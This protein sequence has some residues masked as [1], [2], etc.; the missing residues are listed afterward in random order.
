MSLTV[1]SR[2]QKKS[3]NGHKQTIGQNGQ[4]GQN[5]HRKNGQKIGRN[6]HRIGYNVQT[7]KNG[8]N[9]CTT[10]Y[11]KQDVCKTGHVKQDM[12]NRTC[13]IGQNRQ[14]ELNMTKQSK[15]GGGATPRWI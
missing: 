12:K 14:T 1:L 9:T 7:G 11:L 2:T 6:G 3:K 10:G 15:V 13:K 4:N 5:G 8:H